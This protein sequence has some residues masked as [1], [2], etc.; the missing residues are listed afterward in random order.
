MLIFWGLGK[1]RYPIYTTHDAFHN[2]MLESYRFNQ[3][4]ALM[5]PYYKNYIRARIYLG[6]IQPQ[7]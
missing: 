6:S 7:L 4:G 2:C 3:E 5:K 1:F